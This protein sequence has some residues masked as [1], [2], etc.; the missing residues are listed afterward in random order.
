MRAIFEIRLKAFATLAA[1]SG[2]IKQRWAHRLGCSCVKSMLTP[3]AIDKWLPFANPDEWNKT[4]TD[5]IIHL[6]N[7]RLIQTALMTASG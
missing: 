2:W 4:E 1:N 3:L 6:P 7:L 5:I